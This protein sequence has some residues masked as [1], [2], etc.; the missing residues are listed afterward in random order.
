M[1][2]RQQITADP[3]AHAP[4]KVLYR[5]LKPYVKKCVKILKRER[6]D[7]AR[8]LA[9]AL[10]IAAGYDAAA[11]KAFFDYL[12]DPRFADRDYG[13]LPVKWIALQIQHPEL[14]RLYVWRRT[15]HM[16]HMLFLRASED[17]L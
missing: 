4:A 17:A 16:L 5:K 1:T 13:K 12:A 7:L 11:E 15:A 2:T 10:Y 3:Y 9:S 8:S 14:R 6:C